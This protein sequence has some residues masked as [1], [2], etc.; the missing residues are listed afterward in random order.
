MCI[1]YIFFI[2]TYKKNLQDPGISL[3]T[4]ICICDFTFVFI[5]NITSRRSKT[6]PTTSN[7]QTKSCQSLEQQSNHS[8]L[9]WSC[10]HVLCW[11]WGLAGEVQV[12]FIPCQHSVCHCSVR[13]AVTDHP[14]LPKHDS[15]PSI[16]P[17]WDTW[18]ITIH[19]CLKK[20]AHQNRN[21]VF[22]HSWSITYGL[23]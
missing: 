22:P 14:T 17:A 16:C 6:K 10:C 9:S 2:H 19:S 11:S 18:V 21:Q 23:F 5:C 20:Q 12:W 1:S 13:P 7:T 8:F 3:V 4:F 15:I